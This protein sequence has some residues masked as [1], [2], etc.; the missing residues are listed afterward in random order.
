MSRA[1]A[2][3]DLGAISRNCARL[4]TAAGGAKLCAVIKANG[5]GHGMLPVA[6]AALAGGADWLGVAATSEALVLREMG[7]E[8]P[9]LVMGSVESS[10]VP[11]LCRANCDIVCWTGDALDWAIEAGGV[12][13]HIKIDSGMGR[14]GTRDPEE[15]VA[16]AHRA[17]ES[18]VIELVGVMT[19][20]ATADDRSDDGF[21]EEQN[22]VFSAFATE[23][24][25]FAPEVIA[26]AAN[27][28]ATL[29]LPAAHHDM[30]RCGIGIY[31]L[32]P[33]HA[34]PSQ[35]GLEPAM[36]LRT[37][38]ASIKT[39]HEGESIGYGR[40]FV[41]QATT[42]IATCPIG[43]AD[44]V[45][46][47]LGGRAECL[48]GGNLLPIVGRVSMDNIAIDLGPE[49]TEKEGDIVTLF[50]EEGGNRVLV[51]DW[52]A[53][54]ETINYEI[55]TGIGGRVVPNYRGGK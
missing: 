10:D 27:S 52:A 44:G 28:A 43:Y 9:V 38:I 15:A 39:A 55:V 33:F 31:G 21:L 34:D 42:R 50:G 2:E 32:D 4:K 25:S 30:V 23:V 7:V 19:H 1:T 14:L 45:R 5:Y 54:A 6:E 22:R 13:V 18:Q 36:S 26:H 16:L 11:T 12:R 29:R 35:S 53:A 24:K 20:F 17:Q 47:I 46:R 49:G 3:V 48:G 40:A 37:F 41:A 8:V 51:E